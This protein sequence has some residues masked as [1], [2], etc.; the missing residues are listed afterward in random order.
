MLSQSFDKN[1]LLLSIHWHP[2]SKTARKQK[3][4]EAM[5]EKF[6]QM[7][8][9]LTIEAIDFLYE[10]KIMVNGNVFGL[11]MDLGL[12]IFGI[13]GVII[14]PMVHNSYSL[15]VD[16]KISFYEVYFNNWLIKELCLRRLKKLPIGCFFYKPSI[17]R[18]LI[19]CEKVLKRKFI[20]ILNFRNAIVKPSK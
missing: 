6:L 16:L 13:E 15:L 10:S 2:N 8:I 19:I 7:I 5:K 20:L 14:W 17:N 12:E 11:E 3:K 4:L 9:F 18:Y 1:L